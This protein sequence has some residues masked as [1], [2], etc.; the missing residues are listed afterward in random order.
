MSK[1]IPILINATGLSERNVRMIIRNAPVRYKTY[2]IPKRNGNMRL[3]S[4]PAREVKALQR[5]LVT[6]ILG[7]LPIH[8]SA[9][10]YR[11]GM[12]I[13]DNA[14][15]H[16]KNGPIM[17][18]DFREFFP[19][20]L[21]R[22]WRTYCET[23]SLFEDAE[24]ILL[25]TNILFHRSKES[26]VLRLAIGA[27]SSPCLSNVLMFTFDTRISDLVSADHVTYTRYADDLTFSAKRTGY[28]TG[29]EKAL[30]HV[31]HQTRSPSLTINESKT[32]LATKKYKR[33]VTGLV[34][35]NDGTV[36][37][38]HV[39]KRAIRA[40]VHHASQGRLT[41]AGQAH[42]AGLFGFAQAVE[43][44]FLGRLIDKYGATLIA[45]IK[46]T[47]NPTHS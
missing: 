47:K 42:L 19:S 8:P 2:F 28:L 16:A 43:P 14:A 46:A 7:R 22:D 10:A 44:E 11:P 20:I 35:T 40:A 29:V 3:I 27:P 21:A 1:L 23:T 36:S 12:S 39:R 6:V 41:E 5:A 17:K 33:V 34:L 4:Q 38:G 24:D 45:D 30:R 26:T 31:I 9:T 37:I 13:R 32:V 15:T 25:S 18:F